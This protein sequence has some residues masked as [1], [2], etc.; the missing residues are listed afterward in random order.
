M[1]LPM[2]PQDSPEE[3]SMR[4][5]HTFRR[6]MHCVPTQFLLAISEKARTTERSTDDRPTPLGGPVD[7]PNDRTT[8]GT[9][10]C[11]RPSELPD[12]LHA[13]KQSQRS[14]NRSRTTSPKRPKERYW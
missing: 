5:T 12:A 11:H 8:A 10:V 3:P 6:W 7:R 14:G 13:R 4:I 2:S 9:F 1:Q